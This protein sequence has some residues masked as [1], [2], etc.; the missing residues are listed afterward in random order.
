MQHKINI[1]LDIIQVFTAYTIAF[2]ISLMECSEYLK[3]LSFLIATGYTTWKWLKEY[4][5]SKKKKR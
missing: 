5:E 3:S 4:K 1:L 2:T